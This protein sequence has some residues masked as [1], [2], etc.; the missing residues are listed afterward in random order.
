MENLSRYSQFE[1]NN[2]F[3]SYVQL[4]FHDQSLLP[5][6]YRRPLNE[7]ARI[8]HLITDMSKLF[9]G[10]KT[11]NEPINNWN[12]SN[13]K[14]MSEMFWG[15]TDFNQPIDDWDVSNVEDMSNMFRG[16]KNFNQP[17]QSWNVIKVK[18]MRYM[19]AGATSFNQPIGNWDVSNVVK[20][21]YMFHKAKAFNQPI[22]SWNVS[23]VEDMQ[24]MFDEAESFN[25]PLESWNM[26][27]VIDI[28][29]M[30]QDATSFNQPLN[31]WDVSNVEFMGSIFNGATSFNQPLTNWNTGLDEDSIIELFDGA[32]SF[33]RVNMPHP[34]VQNDSESETESSY[35]ASN[36]SDN[37]ESEEEQ[38]NPLVH[39]NYNNIQM[40]SQLEQSS[41]TLNS[42][43]VGEDTIMQDSDINVK[44][45]LNEDSDNC[46][47]KVFGNYFLINK[48]TIKQNILNIGTDGKINNL[49]VIKFGCK[50]TDEAL[51]PRI[52]NVHS[53]KPCFM[54][55]A[56]G[57]YGGLIYMNQLKYFLETPEIQC[58]EVCD[59]PEES[60]PSTASLY[61]FT[62][63]ANAVS[64][65]HCQQGQE[66]VAR[67]IKI[68]NINATDATEYKG[69][70]RRMSR[71]RKR[72]ATCSKK[73]KRNSRKYGKIN[74]KTRKIIKC[75]KRNNCTKIRNMK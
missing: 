47:F 72:N 58:V 29:N 27:Y 71:N 68:I 16:A 62:R 13:V 43:D 57:I 4:Y 63:Y 41:L 23:N 69:G 14:N 44:Q 66:D 34:V 25:Q 11:M 39:R 59:P 19:F 24:G 49:S 42:T 7:W 48:N 9:R 46:A 1:R 51:I 17:L 3:K 37:G 15:A 26:T 75:R 50:K 64:S 38:I 20:M 70:K 30:F 5:R 35:N 28:Q 67:N 54:L 55:R 36:V 6:A 65:S 40:S 53:D 22:G 74:K 33:E 18:N 2:I 10:I 52:N 56:M 60:Y 73:K 61:M 32:T 31:S 21:S 45:Y 12:V 8:T